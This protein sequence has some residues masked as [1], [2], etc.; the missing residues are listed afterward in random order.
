M[1]PNKQEKRIMH[2]GLA[3]EVA[4]LLP[5]FRK[6]QSIENSKG[7]AF[8]SEESEP[9]NPR[10]HKLRT[11]QNVDEVLNMMPEPWIQYSAMMKEL[12]RPEKGRGLISFNF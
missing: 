8:E 2:Y 1:K 6:Y 11:L 5:N 3:R 4:Q 9:F 7:F 10:K 12:K